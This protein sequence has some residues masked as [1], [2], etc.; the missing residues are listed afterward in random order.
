MQPDTKPTNT[1]RESEIDLGAF[2]DLARQLFS[3]I[4][5]AIGS[6]F[7]FLFQLILSLFIFIKRKFIWLI[8]GLLAGLSLGAF[9]YFK[10]GPAYYSDMVVRVNAETSRSLYNTIEHFNSLISDGK[11]KELAAIFNI[12]E[13]NSSK[14]IRFE[15]S[16]VDDEIE[17]AKLYKD[18]IS[19]DNPNNWKKDTLWVKIIKYQDFKDALTPFNYSLQHIKV[20]SNSPD[21]YQSIQNGLVRKLEQYKNLLELQNK[22][23]DVLKEKEAILSRSLRGI[24]SLRVAYNKSIAQGNAKGGGGNVVAGDNNKSFNSPEIELFDK[25]MQL[26]DEIAA[27]RNKLIEQQNV[28]HIASDINASGTKVSNYNQFFRYAWMGLLISFSL[29]LLI[30]CYRFLDKMDKKQGLKYPEPDK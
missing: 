5:A 30:E 26:N 23:R 18:F 14:L 19:G 28:F 12:T 27:I 17:S 20:Y 11:T 15:I 13:A 7:S 3:S 1:Q 16:P 9:L 4:A 22:A 29:V 25:E 24:D 8:A 21:I 6:F 2:F 10:K